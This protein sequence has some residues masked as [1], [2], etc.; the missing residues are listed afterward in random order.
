M[1]P[2]VFGQAQALTTLDDRPLVVLTA[3]E[4]ADG[5]AG[6]TTA[7]ARL[8][9]L[10]TNTLRRLVDSTHMGLLED[11]GPARQ[12]AVAVNRVIDA[13]RSGAPLNAG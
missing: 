3:K 1:L 9:A 7:Q 4:T 5:T 10:S 12:S 11:Q 8:A 13:V 6:W 2:E